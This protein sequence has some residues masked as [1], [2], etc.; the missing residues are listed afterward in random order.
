MTQDDSIKKK[1]PIMDEEF[2]SM[3]KLWY[4][5][6]N[7]LFNIIESTKYRETAFL[8]EYCVRCMK[9]NA[10]R[11]LQKNFD[12]NRF[13]Q[14]PFMIYFSLSKFPNIPMFSFNQQERREQQDEFNTNYLKFITGYD[15]L[16]DFDN[17]NLM[18]SYSTTYKVKKIF[19]ERKIPY[20]LIFS[21]SKGFHIRVHYEDMC[22][23]LKSMSF[24][25]LCLL[26][27]TFAENFKLKEKLFDIDL[28]IFD[29]RRIAKVPYSIAYPFYFV[30][31][32]LTDEQFENFSLK[33]VSL[34]YLL[35]RTDKL[36]KRGIL[37]RDGVKGN[38]KKLIDEYVLNKNI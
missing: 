8:G 3:R 2:E 29:L 10:V 35:E 7:I 18:L 36:Y 1:I 38:F 32:P 12:R 37:K 20:S 25:D 15:F 22:D 19:D 13:F 17:P 31:L 5:N 26:F 33:Q 9:V 11:Y 4:K 6:E 21:G 24:P 14:K 34:P 16:F 28:G 23:E 30:A 27:K